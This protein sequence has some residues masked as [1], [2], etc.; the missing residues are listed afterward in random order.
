MLLS[1][2]YKN[3]NVPVLKLN[4]RQVS[5]ITAVKEKIATGQ[6]KTE[7]VPCAV[8]GAKSFAPLANKDRYG[9]ELSF[10][11]C[12]DCGLAQTNPRMDQQAYNEFYDKEYRFIYGGEEGPTEAFFRDQYFRLGK[13]IAGFIL[14]H[15][16]GKPL[17]GKLVLEI[18]C[19]AG[20]I[21]KYFQ[22]QG[23]RV[24][25]IDLGSQFV[26][27]GKTAHNLDLEVQSIDKL[28]LQHKPDIIIYS[29]VLEHILDLPQQLANIRR[30]MGEETLLYIEVPGLRNLHR[31]YQGDLLQYLQNAHVYHFTKT[32]LL[33]L[34]T[35]NGFT[36]VTID[37][38]VRSIFKFSALKGSAQPVNEY[39]GIVAYL[40]RIELLRKLFP[41]APYL[42]KHKLKR[43]VYELMAF[44]RLV[45][46]LQDNKKWKFHEID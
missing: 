42:M 26:Q 17:K 20:G 5:Y 9:F 43:M 30:L 10:V 29:H 15:S 4:Q 24:K 3:D 33:N 14:Q 8:C 28:Q 23:C 46:K 2:R 16:Q 31:S 13:K 39:P 27:F 11:V 40:K 22:D 36:P 37:E 35:A 12:R 44:A 19:G 45:P 6:Y 1:S 18:G 25:G 34:T 41:V 32:S 21:L 7:H 38:S